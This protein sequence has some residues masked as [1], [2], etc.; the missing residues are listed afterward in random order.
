MSPVLIFP[1]RLKKIV[2]TSTVSNGVMIA[3]PKP[4]NDCL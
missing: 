4:K 2:K 1:M 3:H